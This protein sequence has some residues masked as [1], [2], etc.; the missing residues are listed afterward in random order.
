MLLPYLII[1]SSQRLGYL[2][3]CLA[4]SSWARKNGRWRHR[5]ARL[6]GAILAS[7]IAAESWT[8]A[9]RKPH[10]ADT[11]CIRTYAKCGAGKHLS[12]AAHWVGNGI[13]SVATSNK[14]RISLGCRPRIL[15]LSISPPKSIF[16][17]TK[18][19]Y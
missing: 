3:R 5:F 14:N 9:D 12:G 13:T 2:A 4:A 17:S 11:W 19:I 16:S 10:Q 1:V 7:P 6:A 18:T 15:A 8:H